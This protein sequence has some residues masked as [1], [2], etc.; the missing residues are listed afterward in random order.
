M[1]RTSHAR[2]SSRSD[3]VQIASYQRWLALFFAAVE[4]PSLYRMKSQNFDGLPNI[5]ENGG[6]VP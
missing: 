3:V 5:S 6:F 4:I 1:G 2:Q